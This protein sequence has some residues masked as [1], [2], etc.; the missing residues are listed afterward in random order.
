M[1]KL[2]ACH[3]TFLEICRHCY[4]NK[5]M[6]SNIL[7]VSLTAITMIFISSCNPD[8]NPGLVVINTE[9][10]WSG[11][12]LSIGDTVTDQM[13]HNVRPEK[14]SCYISNISL[15][16]V[17]GEWINSESISRLDFIPNSATANGVF[18]KK[19]L[20]VGNEFDGLRFDVGVPSEMNS[21]TLNTLLASDDPL[22]V[23][24]AA[25]MTWD[26]M[27]SYFF[28]KCEG[29]LAENEGGL[30]QT[31]YIFHPASNALY[32]TVTLDLNESIVLNKDET[33]E[34]MLDLDLRKAFEGP[35]TEDNLNLSDVG[36]AMGPVPKAIQFVDNFSTSWSIK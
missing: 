21:M 22:S 4:N 26:M 28:V 24:G 6:K 34:F 9:L 8:E 7:L 18:S 29:K 13:G 1:S 11:E 16:N 33:I 25:G 14:L 12:S 5:K 35:S 20:R 32:R 15:R 3:A 31:P 36:H 10:S 19:M 27:G 2:I 17:S 23:E 30:I